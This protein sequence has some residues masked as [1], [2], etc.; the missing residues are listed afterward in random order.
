MGVTEVTLEIWG[1]RCGVFWTLFEKNGLA[2][3][4]QIIRT[5][6]QPN[7]FKRTQND[8]IW[9]RKTLGTM[10]L[11]KNLPENRK[12]NN[13]IRKFGLPEYTLLEDQTEKWWIDPKSKR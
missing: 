6:E 12:I 2:I 13:N 11:A 10:L 9:C 7:V 8:S 3:S 1:G 4:D 5:L